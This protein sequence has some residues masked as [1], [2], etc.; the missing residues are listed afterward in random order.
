M[1]EQEM[2]TSME[3]LKSTNEITIK[4]TNKFSV[5]TVCKW[6][7]YQI[8][9]KNQPANQPAHQQTINQQATTPKEY[10]NIEY[11]IDE[12]KSQK[13]LFGKYV[14]MEEKEYE[15]L[16]E[17]YGAMYIGKKI[18]ALDSYIADWKGKKYKDHYLTINKRSLGDMPEVWSLGEE[19]LKAIEGKNTA[20]KTRLENTHS[21]EKCVREMKTFLAGS[22]A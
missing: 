17:K 2:R 7:E 18:A 15:K 4:S 5:I 12:S 13:K 1:S 21:K 8:E 11:N 14:A 6:E 16:V 19:Y 9:N 10:K 22:F 20:A 3:H